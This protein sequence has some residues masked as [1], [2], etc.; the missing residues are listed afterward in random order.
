MTVELARPRHF[1]QRSRKVKL[2][3]VRAKIGH[4]IFLFSDSIARAK[5]RREMARAIF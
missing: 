2:N 5:D 1:N 4:D 3:L